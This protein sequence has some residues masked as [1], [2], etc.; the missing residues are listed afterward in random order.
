M[1]VDFIKWNK[2]L[3]FICKIDKNKSY[4]KIK[5]RII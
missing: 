3:F 2:T 4:K 1:F 5:R